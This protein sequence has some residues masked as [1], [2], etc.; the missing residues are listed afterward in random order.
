VVRID[1]KVMWM[2][3]IDRKLRPVGG[4]AGGDER[5]EGRWR[6]LGSEGRRG[7]ARRGIGGTGTSDP[8]GRWGQ[9]DGGGAARDTGR[10]RVGGGA[11][12][13]CGLAVVG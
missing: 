9:R 2:V 11:R 5:A 6:S 13:R 1:R 7:A 10:L 12:L 3:K 8:D 4:R